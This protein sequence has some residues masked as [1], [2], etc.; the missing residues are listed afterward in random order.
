MEEYIKRQI[1]KTSEGELYYELRNSYNFSPKESESIIETA[2]QYLIRENLLK[3][4]EIEVTVIALEERSGKILE[5]MKKVRVRLTI[6]N[7]KEDREVLREFGRKG[8]RQIQIQRITEEALEQ[9][10]VLSQ[11]DISKYIGCDVRTIKRYIKGIHE[12]GIEV[13]TRGVLHNIGR[14][15]THKQK[16]VGY[17]L[18][19]KTFSEIK[20]ITQ[21]S[22][23][24]IKRYLESFVRVLMSI[25][26]RIFSPKD[27]SSVTGISEHLVLQYLDLIHESRKET[28]CRLK[29][30]ELITQ[31]KL[32][33]TRLKKSSILDE[34]GIKVV[35][36]TGGVI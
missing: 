30:E 35:H 24:S 3:E 6:D 10:G 29:M 7:G 14:G 20:L 18:V 1:Q 31:Y 25:H 33:G 15:Q 23:G 19:G 27:I 34:F 32:A 9:G 12:K 36:M 16:I 13:I 17:Y 22:I 21:H 8:L 11:E 5:K 2:K 28:R 26:Q 4:G